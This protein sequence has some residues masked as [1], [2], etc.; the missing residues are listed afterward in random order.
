M[1][2]RV[3]PPY[4]P[5]EQQAVEEFDRDV[6]NQ[7]K[8]IDDVMDFKPQNEQEG[9]KVVDD[10]FACSLYQMEVNRL[11]YIANFIPSYKIT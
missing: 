5:Y 8:I 3:A 10:D 6:N 7:Q 11:N 1:N 9:T 4:T 2:E